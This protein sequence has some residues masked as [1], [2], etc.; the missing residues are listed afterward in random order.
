M[1]KLK[2]HTI[3]LTAIRS[4]PQNPRSQVTPEQNGDFAV[5][6][7]G[8]LVPG[9][10][11]DFIEDDELRGLAASLGS[12][13]DS[14]LVEPPVVE[15]VASGAYRIVA[16]ER[17][18]QA[19]RLAGWE[20]IACL[21]Y[22]PLDP[23]KA[24]TLRLMEN[25]HRQELHPLDQA[26][27]LKIAWLTA[28]ADAMGLQKQARAVLAI[29]QSPGETLIA[30]DSLLSDRKFTPTRPAVTWDTVL[31]NLGVALGRTRRMRLL[32]VLGVEVKVQAR[33]RELE[34]S[35]S[36]LR[37][38]GQLEPE[39]QEQLVEAIEDDPELAKKV[40]R[41]AHAVK[42]HKYELDEALSEAQGEI[43]LEAEP[44]APEDEDL[45]DE[46]QIMDTVVTLMELAD[47]FEGLVAALNELAPG[48]TWKDLPAPWGAYAQ[49][50]LASIETA[51]AKGAADVV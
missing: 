2:L 34:V 51:L 13:D 15:E 30:L 44:D 42:H 3:P 4:T 8:D 1:A 20:Q 47:Q 50:S 10:R 9:K 25:L 46:D 28:N 31:D 33:V 40:R 37:A 5:P 43:V 12:P 6:S 27:G 48:G 35:A 14:R 22:P 26:A 45:P 16:G 39:E 18:I 24:H 19:A 17:R 49:K 21:T 23:A 36:G 32:R 7:G 38:L 41:I 29:E 11:R